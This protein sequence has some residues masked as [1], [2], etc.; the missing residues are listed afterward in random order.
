MFLFIFNLCYLFNYSLPIYDYIVHLVICVGL[1][2]L[3]LEK[4][5]EPSCN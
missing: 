3:G 2:F 1:F 5:S 4:L